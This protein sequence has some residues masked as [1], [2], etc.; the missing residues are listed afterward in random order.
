MFKSNGCV[1]EADEKYKAADGTCKS[2]YVY[3]EKAVGYKELATNPTTDQI[4]QAIYNYGPVWACVCAGTNFDAYKSGVLTKSDGT[5]VNHAIV[6]CGWDDATSSWVLRNSW[7]TS[8]GEN[9]GYMRIKWG[10]S[11]VG[12][13]ATYIDYKGIIDHTITSVSNLHPSASI[14]LSPN[15]GNGALTFS[16]LESINTIE[17]YDLVGNLVYQAQSNGATALVDL[18]DKSQGMY[19]YKVINTHGT[20][21]GK[22][23]VY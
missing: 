13:K 7:G 19:L 9:S 17:V 11:S 16:G 3:H 8:W 2:T 23:M 10:V 15:P 22:L 6:L 12:Y 4:K 14:Q 18:K 20:N 5:T 1:Y 21:S